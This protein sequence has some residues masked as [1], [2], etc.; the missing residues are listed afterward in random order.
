MSKIY[1]FYALSEENTPQ[2][3]RYIGV[4]ST[5]LSQRFSGHKYCATH[6]AKRNCP[7][8]KWMYSVY[9]KG[10]NIIYTKLTECLE[11]EW[12]ITEKTLIK[13]Y[14]KDHLLLNVDEGGR[15]VITKEKRNI[16][17]IERSI[18]AHEKTIVLIDP[19]GETFEI[20]NSVKE[21]SEKFNLNK[22]SIGNVLHGRS[23]TCGGYYIT[24]YSEFCADNFNIQDFINEKNN[25]KAKFKAIYQFDLSGNLINC[26]KSKRLLSKENH[27][28]PNAILKAINN[29]TVYKDC[30]WSYASKIDQNEFKS[31]YKYKYD[32]ILY[33][34]QASLG[35]VLNLSACTISAHV[36]QHIPINGKLIEI[37]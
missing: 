23:I 36:V 11:D 13:Q 30:Y 35:K 26:F 2:T 20:C 6:A 28:S 19:K 27:F 12:E 17:G 31:P 1:Q 5:S 14:N 8:H 7:V 4:T 18:K 32:G 10:G 16:S 22:T 24:T 37:L 3:F 33:K 15:G 25:S 9:Q 34:T 29:K 21:A